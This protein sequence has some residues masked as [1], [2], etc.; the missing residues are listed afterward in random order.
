MYGKSY[1][2]AV[3]QVIKVA[4]G[5]T[6]GGGEGVAIAKQKSDEPVYMEMATGGI[7]IGLGGQKYRTIFLFETQAAFDEFVQDGWEAD[8]E[9]NAAA[10]NKG[11]NKAASF[12]NGVAIFQITDKGL[13]ANADVSGTKYWTDDELNRQS[14]RE[15]TD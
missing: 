1:G 8:A 9:A 7:G 4:I 10:G 5:V 11:A 2:V 15:R 13:L 12:S 14:E 6:G 3:F